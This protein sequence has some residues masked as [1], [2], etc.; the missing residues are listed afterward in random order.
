MR[1]SFCLREC[2]NRGRGRKR[3]IS[4]FVRRGRDEGDP[5]GKGV[6]AFDGFSITQKCGEN[7][8]ENRKECALLGTVS[9]G[10]ENER[11]NNCV[12]CPVVLN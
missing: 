3:K 11:G 6:S 7:V 8:L 4:A 12:F 10:D 1:S 9:G 2:Y 5:K